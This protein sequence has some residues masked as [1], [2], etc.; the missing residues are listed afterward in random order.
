MIRILSDSDRTALQIR[1]VLALPLFRQAAV[2]HAQ[3]TVPGAP[4]LIARL[5]V[6]TF[7]DLPSAGGVYVTK[8]S[9]LAKGYFLF[10]D[11]LVQ[12]L[13]SGRLG[14]ALQVST[15]VRAQNSLRGQVKHVN[16]G[17]APMRA[18][19]GGNLPLLAVRSEWNLSNIP[20]PNADDDLVAIPIQSQ[21]FSGLGIAGMSNSTLSTEAPDEVDFYFGHYIRGHIT[22][23][24]SPF[25]DAT[26]RPIRNTSPVIIGMSTYIDTNITLG[27]LCGRIAADALDVTGIAADQVK[28]AVSSA[29]LA[30][31]DEV[32]ERS[33]TPFKLQVPFVYTAGSWH[34]ADPGRAKLPLINPA[35]P[36]FAQPR[37]DVDA[38]PYVAQVVGRQSGSTSSASGYARDYIDLPS[39]GSKVNYYPTSGNGN[40][41]VGYFGHFDAPGTVSHELIGSRQGTTLYCLGTF[42]SVMTVWAPDTGGKI[43]EATIALTDLGQSSQVT[44]I[45]GSGVGITASMGNYTDNTAPMFYP[46]NLQVR[47]N[48]CGLDDTLCGRPIRSIL[49]PCSPGDYYLVDGTVSEVV[50]GTEAFISFT[51]KY[52]DDFAST[53]TPGNGEVVMLTKMVEEE[54]DPRGYL[55]YGDERA[56]TLVKFEKLGQFQWLNSVTE[57]LANAANT[58]LD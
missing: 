42:S 11:A 46:R 12:A 37:W 57:R 20:I 25:A 27:N 56:T 45:G 41:P 15:G 39:S 2:K 14:N 50:P 40:T 31:K 34:I 8:L 33:R 1:G 53:G 21:A 4:P 26:R 36:G 49:A 54:E 29:M 22:T 7:A 10:G 23:V 43:S 48:I 52:L 19:I 17:Q 55:R 5:D 35:T 47:L 24:L 6:Q 32:E 38:V 18:T 28:E 9:N 3:F 44:N 16:T 13:R 58:V 30:M 51:E